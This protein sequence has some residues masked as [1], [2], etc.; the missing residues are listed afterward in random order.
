MAFLSSESW[1][2]KPLWGENQRNRSPSGKIFWASPFPHWE[3]EGLRELVEKGR[4]EVR[5]F[6]Y[7][8]RKRK[9]R[10]RKRREMEK[11]K[12]LLGGFFLL[13]LLLFK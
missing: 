3:D 5:D 9:K 13:H 2:L 4:K 1:L 10:R 7:E 12:D 8:R 6:V 11:K